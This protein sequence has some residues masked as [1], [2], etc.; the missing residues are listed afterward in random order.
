MFVG[1]GPGSFLAF[2]DVMCILAAGVFCALWY[3]GK[4]TPKH[5]GKQRYDYCLMCRNWSMISNHFHS[6]EHGFNMADSVCWLCTGSWSMMLRGLNSVSAALSHVTPH[7]IR[8]N[9]SCHIQSFRISQ[10]PTWLKYF[11]ATN[12]SGTDF[13]YDNSMHERIHRSSTI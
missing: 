8:L 7:P 3:V 4:Q 12:G 1:L 2:G 5:A 11:N 13:A 10:F 9:S 6:Y